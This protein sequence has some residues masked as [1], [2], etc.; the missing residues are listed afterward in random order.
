M[1]LNIELMRTQGRESL[2]RLIVRAAHLYTSF[3]ELKDAYGMVRL[4]KIV[5]KLVANQDFT[6][7]CN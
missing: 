7:E 2:L 3:S 4:R 6:Q 5:L 1:L